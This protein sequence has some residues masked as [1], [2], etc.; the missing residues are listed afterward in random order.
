ME[1]IHYLMLP[2]PAD[3]HDSEWA[4]C[5][6]LIP[7]LGQYLLKQNCFPVTNTKGNLISTL[8]FHKP[9]IDA[10]HIHWPDQIYSSAKHP[11]PFFKTIYRVLKIV[12]LLSWII[13]CK[14]NRIRVIWTVHDLYPHP[15]TPDNYDSL[16]WFMRRLFMRM[17]HAII[18]NGASGLPCIER[19]FGKAK[20]VFIAPL[21]NYKVF[22]PNHATYDT[23]RQ[24]F[25]LQPHHRTFLF[26]G[27]V[28]ENR[29]PIELIKLFSTLK[30]D[31]LRLLVAATWFTQ[32]IKERIEAIAA[33]DKRIMLNFGLLK[34][35]IAEEYFSATDIVVVPSEYYLTSAVIVTAISFHKPVIADMFGCAPSQIKDAGFLYVAQEK[36]SLLK[37]LKCAVECDLQEYR[38][39]AQAVAQGLSWD[40]CAEQI[41][42][43]YR[44][45]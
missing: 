8:V 18:I 27:T 4:K 37:A 36:G 9:K 41:A 19:E 20:R 38:R 26:F 16:E 13:T 40:F 39:R 6:P 7:I 3:E 1:T 21:G 12:Y 32:D 5:H 28:H 23:G 22:Y 25:G 11:S 33:N 14:I 44:S 43:A 34:P 31:N 17:S 30:N 42:S 2:N 35:E 10:F 15:Q 24:K 29:N 45:N